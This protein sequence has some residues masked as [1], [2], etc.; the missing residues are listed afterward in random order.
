MVSHAAPAALLVDGEQPT[1]GQMTKEAFLD[2]LET[3]VTAAANDELGPA[4]SAAGCPYIERYFRMYRI[5]PAAQTEAVIRKYTRSTAQT[6]AALIPEVVSRVREGVRRWVDTGAT[7]AE[8]ALFDPGAVAHAENREQSLASLEDE[9]GAGESLDA[10]TAQR[11]HSV[12]ADT[13]AVR[14]HTGTVAQRMTA[15]NHAL[16][17][18]SGANIMFAAGAYKPGDLESEALVAHELAHVSQQQTAATNPMERQAPLGREEAGAE[19]HADQAAGSVLQ[20]LSKTGKNWLNQVGSAFTTGLTVQRCSQDEAAKKKTLKD[21][22]TKAL[23]AEKVKLEAITKT[24]SGASLGE[25]GAAMAKLRD[26][27]HDLAVLTT[28]T[29][30]YTGNRSTE[31]TTG[32]TPAG[33]SSTDCTAFVLDVLKA[34]FSQ[35]GK[36]ADWAKVE[37]RYKVNTT[38]RGNNKMSGLDVQ[39]AL[40]SEAGWKGIF[41]APDPGYQVPKDQLSKAKSDEA[42]YAYGKAK[43]GTYYKGFGKKKYPGVTIAHQVVNYAPENPKAGAGNKSPTTQDTTGLEKLKKLT[44]GVLAAHGGQHMSIISNGKVIEVHWHASSNE[45]NVI[46]QGDLEHWAVGPK[47]GYHFF[48]SGA[49]VAPAADV[50]SAFK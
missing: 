19:S 37:K 7:P 9:L 6:A 13:S 41:W 23:R 2:E 17:A 16:A 22:K 36:A 46:T 18:T 14:I 33:V 3:Q 43:K 11:L 1:E 44:F 29:G 10:G 45:L 24:G 20:R 38:L 5:K 25:V 47:S 30:L 28:G 12:G 42:S 8:A 35:Q 21:E 40:Q 27:K 4:W 15:D 34:T 50:D 32:K 49:I 26:V 39:A 48:A 31:Y